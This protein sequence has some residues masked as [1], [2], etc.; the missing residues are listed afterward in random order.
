M[1]EFHIK[2]RNDIE[3]SHSAFCLQDVP[4]FDISWR[5]VDASAEVS[6]R[7]IFAGKPSWV[8]ASL[9]LSVSLII[10]IMFLVSQVKFNLQLEV[11]QVDM[12]SGLMYLPTDHVCM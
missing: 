2:K 12:S 6:K 8:V 10:L 3:K 5:T 1:L 9:D 11:S 7:L 4:L